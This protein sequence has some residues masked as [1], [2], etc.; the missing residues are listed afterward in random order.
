MIWQLNGLTLASCC[1]YGLLYDSDLFFVIISP[2][3]FVFIS[4]QGCLHAS[5]N[6]QWHQFLCWLCGVRHSRLHG[7]R[8]GSGHLPSGW[9][10]YAEH[11]HTTEVVLYSGVSKPTMVLT[12]EYY[13]RLWSS[14]LGMHETVHWK[15]W[16]HCFTFKLAAPL[17]LRKTAVPLQ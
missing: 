14:L 4:V 3:V 9:N 7:K 12:G 5:S 6:Q 17:V 11:T 8:A 2:F 10:R 15:S 1:T 16:C 13:W